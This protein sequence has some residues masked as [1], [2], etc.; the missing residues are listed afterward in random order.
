MAKQI[1]YVYSEEHPETTETAVDK[2]NDN[3]DELYAREQVTAGEKSN[4]HAPHSDDQDLSGKADLIDGWVPASQLPSFVYAII[5]LITIA[6][7]DPLTGNAGEKYFNTTSKKILTYATGWGNPVDPEHSKIYVTLDAEKTY[8]WSGT[9]LVEISESLALG[10]SAASAY[11]G[12]RGKTAYDHSQAAHAPADAV[13]LT[14]V[15]SD[16][17]ISKAIAREFVSI[18]TQEDSY[19]LAA[20]DNGKVVRM[21]KAT[22]QNCTL[23]LNN[24]V[25]IAIGFQCLIRQ[26]GVGQLTFVAELGVTINSV[27]SRLKSATQHCAGIATKINTN[28]WTLDGDLI[29]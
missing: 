20:S 19:I 4:F 24:T 23:P 17:D 1:I 16:S 28:I 8:R 15:K 10:E 22:A 14:T 25:P 6:A 11:R 5:D 12:D 9:T 18:N 27:G 3:F 29:A 13:S 7:T 26:S 21:N 2:M